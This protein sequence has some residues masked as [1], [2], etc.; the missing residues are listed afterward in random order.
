LKEEFQEKLEREGILSQT[1]KSKKDCW[2]NEYIVST[3]HRA[4][5]QITMLVAAVGN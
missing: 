2:K 3:L 5:I 4:P 1:A